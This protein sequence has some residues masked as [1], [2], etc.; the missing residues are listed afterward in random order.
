V[1]WIRRIWAGLGI[2]ALIGFGGWSLVAYR[3][4]GNARAALVSDERVTVVRGASH[5][6]LAPSVTSRREVGLVFFPGALVEPAAYAP[7]LRE[8]ALAGYPALLVE[9]P[10]RGAFGGADGAEVIGRARRAMRGVASVSEWVLS[11]HS[12]G[13]AV[14]ARLVQESGAGISGLV[15]VGTSHPRDFSLAASTLLVTKVLGT[16]DGIA[17]IQKSDANRHLLPATSHWVLIEGGNHSQ[18]G[19]YGF[20]PG[21]SFATIDRHHQQ[22]LTREALVNALDAAARRNTPANH[23][24]QPAGSTGG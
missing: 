15:L 17:P 5:W 18:F 13:G 10:R 9:L 16:R 4:S 8:V 3:A 7:L 14:A 1:Y 2:L 24:L 22:E 19:W 21:D 20:Q 11:G 6:F 12:R 23:A